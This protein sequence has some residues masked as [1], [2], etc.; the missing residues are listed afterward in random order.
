MT[1]PNLQTLA[2]LGLADW[3]AGA[4][5]EIR[6]PGADV[7]QALTAEP[8]S[9]SED[10]LERAARGDIDFQSRER[11]LPVAQALLQQCGLEV[12]LQE[13]TIP[14]LQVTSVDGSPLE[15]RKVG[16][17]GVVRDARVPASA[18]Y[19]DITRIECL[20]VFTAAGE[21]VLFEP[22]SQELRLRAWSPPAASPEPELLVHS[23][24]RSWC[25][26]SEDAWIRQAIETQLL[27]GDAWAEVV[28]TG[29]FARLRDEPSRGQDRERTQA[30]WRWADALPGDVAAE[31][32]ASAVDQVCA[33]EQLLDELSTNFDPYDSVWV[34]ALVGAC[35]ERDDIECVVQLLARRGVNEPLEAALDR[36]DHRGRRLIVDLPIEVP[37]DDERLWRA[38][39][40]APDCW[41]TALT[42]LES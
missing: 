32:Q 9:V 36:L 38:A 40:Y 5:A 25:A 31:L 15:F 22:A 16:S 26:D 20:A 29:M 24:V 28:A 33:V 14:I 21:A 12:A 6:W 13:E 3:D 11:F 37:I 34:R 39:R 7:A 41:W 17:G 27:E 1:E 35:Q 4:A 10:R 30:P 42:G 2:E 18:V 8:A 19:A 23:P